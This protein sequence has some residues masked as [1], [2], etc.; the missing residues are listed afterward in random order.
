MTETVWKLR[1]R[2]GVTLADGRKTIGPVVHVDAAAQRAHVHVNALGYAIER[3]FSAL[4]RV[5]W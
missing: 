1:D 2:A 3:P 4:R 5:A